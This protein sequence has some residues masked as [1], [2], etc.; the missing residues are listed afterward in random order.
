MTRTVLAEL[1]ASKLTPA[2]P[3]PAPFVVTAAAGAAALST[4]LSLPV[5]VCV[6]CAAFSGAAPK[7]EM[8]L[9]R[10]AHR[11][12]SL[13]PTCTQ[14]ATG[15]SLTTVC[16]ST[17]SA[18]PTC[19]PPPSCPVPTLASP[20][21]EP[22]AVPRGRVYCVL[23]AELRRDHLL[24]PSEPEKQRELL[25]AP[26]FLRTAPIS[27]P[28]GLCPSPTASRSSPSRGLPR[29]G[30]AQALRVRPV[31]SSCRSEILQVSPP[32]VLPTVCFRNSPSPLRQGPHSCL[33][34]SVWS[35]ASWRRLWPGTA[36]CP[37]DL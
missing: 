34:L 1:L 32:A 24:I 11:P 20:S 19:A 16:P 5:I 37:V 6:A 4:Y 12:W 27:N 3:L 18:V 25:P 36:G 28:T 9:P 15:Q 22:R 33:R 23:G 31:S 17:T 26:R 8:R 35:L 14:A 30:W 2:G 21:G 13:V 7:A 29:T 10:F